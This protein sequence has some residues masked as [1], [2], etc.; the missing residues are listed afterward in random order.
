MAGALGG[1]LE[2][3]WYGGGSWSADG[4]GKSGSALSQCQSELCGMGSHV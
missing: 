1:S 2:D 3:T 4:L